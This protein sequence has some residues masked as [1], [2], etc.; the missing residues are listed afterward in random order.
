M[1]ELKEKI[2]K[3]GKALNTEVLKV[4]SF[5]NHQVDAKLM[6]EIGKCFAEKF[7]NRGITKVVTIESSGI[8]PSICT[9]FHLGV[10]LIVLKKSPTRVLS[11]NII[12][13]KIVSFT[14]GVEFQLT[15][16]KDYMTQ[17][18]KVLIIDDFLAQGEAATG[19]IRLIE[20][21]GAKIEG[22]GILIEKSFQPGSKILSELGYE[23]YSLA[24][25]KSLQQ[26]I[27]EFEE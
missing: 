16:N 3:Y 9:S 24:K 23:V 21:Q 13:T 27:I 19:A 12:Q 15:M 11:E 26:G 22:I 8:A 7:K 17:E 2:L 6:N 4:D 25:I 5:I 1:K 10:D 14:K 20:K 18:D